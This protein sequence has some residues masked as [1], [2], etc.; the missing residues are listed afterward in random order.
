MGGALRGRAGAQRA[1]LTGKAGGHLI[2][3]RSALCTPCF[4]SAFLGVFIHHLPSRLSHVPFGMRWRFLEHVR[5]LRHAS[6]CSDVGLDIRD[7]FFFSQEPV[8]PSETAHCFRWFRHY[9][10]K[11]IMCFGVGVQRKRGAYYPHGYDPRQL[12]DTF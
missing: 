4:V 11:K 5:R 10:I 3:A 9:V 6:N 7:D 1:S 2:P 8:L 12:Y